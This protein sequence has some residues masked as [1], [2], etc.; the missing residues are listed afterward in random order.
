M[1][2]HSPAT[3]TKSKNKQHILSRH[4]S[5]SDLEA[6]CNTVVANLESSLSR[7]EIEGINDFLFDENLVEGNARGRLFKDCDDCDGGDGVSNLSSVDSYSV[8]DSLCAAYLSKRGMYR[9]EQ[10]T[11]TASKA[12]YLLENDFALK[13]IISCRCKI[14]N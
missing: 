1:R 5:H 10:P 14:K 6:S 12:D 9:L 2:R 7:I 13:T 4:N 3:S 8:A 11:A